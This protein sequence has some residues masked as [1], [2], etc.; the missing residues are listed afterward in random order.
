M[1]NIMATDLN[2]LEN[3]KKNKTKTKIF[4]SSGAMLEGLITDFDEIAIVLD[5]CLI[6]TEKIISV[7]PSVR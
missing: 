7:T 3:L 6:Y 1:R 2:Y 4:L 5:K